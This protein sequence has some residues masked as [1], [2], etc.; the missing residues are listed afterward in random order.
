MKTWQ[1]GIRDGRFLSQIHAAV[2]F[3]YNGFVQINGSIVAVQRAHFNPSRILRLVG[4]LR[5]QK[6]LQGA[7]LEVC[8][9]VWTL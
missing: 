9:S 8:G 7:A 1:A 3:T 5:M 6:L 4:A 2:D